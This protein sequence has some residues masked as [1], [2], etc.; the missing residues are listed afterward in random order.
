MAETWDTA[1]ENRNGEDEIIIEENEQCDI[2]NNPQQ[3]NCEV[4][5]DSSKGGT[6]NVG[7]SQQRLMLNKEAV[8][9]AK[10][11]GHDDKNA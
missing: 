2:V 1:S 9:S 11:I 7:E 10:E 6:T 3:E 8:L 5:E 4:G